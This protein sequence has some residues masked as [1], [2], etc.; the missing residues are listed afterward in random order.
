MEDEEEKETQEQNT[1]S[2]ARFLFSIMVFGSASLVFKLAWNLGLASLSNRIPSIGFIHAFTWL[3]M[4]YIVSRVVSAGYMAE[5]ERTINILVED[6][7][8]AVSK[9]DQFASLFSK[10]ENQ[11]VDSSDLN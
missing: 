6:L 8:E 1:K 10:K 4:L 5:V 9:L 3:A 7:Q 11:K 2:T